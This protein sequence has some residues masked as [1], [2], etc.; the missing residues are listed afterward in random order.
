MS[1]RDTRAYAEDLDRADEIAGFRD[2]LQLPEGLIYL[3]G[4]SL[5]PPPK[6]AFD[7]VGQ[8]L[9]TEW[10]D[11]LITSWNS[12]GWF[13][14]SD[15]LGDSLAGLLGADGG[16]IVVTDTTSINLFKALHAA[17]SLNP[18]RAVIVAE[19][20]SFPTDLYMAQGIVA[21]DNRLSLR[22]EGIDGDTIEALIDDDVAAVLVNHVDYRTGRLR[23][24]AALTARAHAAGAIVVWD[25][26]H[27]AGVV[28]VELNACNVDLAVGCTYKYL[29]GG[30]GSPAF[31]FA[32]WRHH[33][34]LSQPLT[35][36]WGHA[37]PF[38]FEQNYRADP[39]IRKFLCGTQPILSLRALKAGLD[40]SLEV[41]Q[42]AIREKSVALSELFISLVE[43]RCD[44]LG[45]NLF[46]PRDPARRGSQVSFSHAHGFSIIQA[47]IERR[48][49]G[50]FRMPDIMRFGFA[51]LYIRYCDVWDA[52]EQ[53]RQVLETEQ[54]REPRF[55]IRG[56]V[57]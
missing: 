27:S 20:G 23:D 44:G 9:R 25:L 17:L 14:L 49:I 32:A 18:D 21:G 46:G 53:L 45:L 33:A 43:S 35:G 47:L 54:W 6:A 48:V 57:T 10:A 7:E 15:T 24:M 1:G 16:E 11:G 51:P 40:L 19:G 38:A 37:S 56:A 12:A 8:A 3:D 13:M 55:A 30:P 50:D 36:W 2:R 22:L 39:G 28:P 34:A 29:N 52:V 31:V 42:H 4:N 26:C 41:D 5:G